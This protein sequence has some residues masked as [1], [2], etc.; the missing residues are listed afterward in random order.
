MDAFS[1]HLE[2]NC[3]RVFS[4][5]TDQNFLSICIDKANEGEVSHDR[6]GILRIK[7][8]LNSRRPGLSMVIT[9]KV[10]LYSILCGICRHSVF[11]KIQQRSLAEED[12]TSVSIETETLKWLSMLAR[13]TTPD[14]Q[15]SYFL[16]RL[17]E[18]SNDSFL[19]CNVS[20]STFN[21]WKTIAGKQCPLTPAAMRNN[22]TFQRIDTKKALERLE[23]GQ[24]LLFFYGPPSKHDIDCNVPGTM[25]A[26]NVFAGVTLSAIQDNN[27]SRRQFDLTVLP[28]SS[29][30][31]VFPLV[32]AFEDHWY[33]IYLHQEVDMEMARFMKSILVGTGHSFSSDSISPH[34]TGLK[35]QFVQTIKDEEEEEEEEGKERN[36]NKKRKPNELA[37]SSS[38]ES[39]LLPHRVAIIIAKAYLLHYTPQ[40]LS[41]SLCGKVNRLNLSLQSES[42]D[43]DAQSIARNI[44]V[45]R[46]ADYIYTED[47]H[48][49]SV[50]PILRALPTEHRSLLSECGVFMLPEFRQD[51]LFSV[52]KMPRMRCVRAIPL[53]S[54]PFCPMTTRQDVLI[55]TL[56]AILIDKKMRA[57]DTQTAIID[58][59]AQQ[60]AETAREEGILHIRHDQVTVPA[61]LM[62]LEKKD[63]SVIN[64][65]KL[66]TIAMLKIAHR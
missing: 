52:M 56:L 6:N 26:E 57:H 19:L 59:I 24:L 49:C 34:E 61:Y 66:M 2:N 11:N 62:A 63:G 41:E 21:I 5:Q 8:I 33:R 25:G 9:S 42:H 31:D 45:P 53:V 14:D 48:V 50:T 51:V 18:C 36:P 55:N 54:T 30:K 65:D 13:Q 12:Q 47:N 37:V 43:D 46:M 28:F 16:K 3:L 15:P 38:D 10:A 27:D 4:G 60:V 17:E 1:C 39:A 35:R 64:I 7:T 23:A 22:S 29:Q 58:T 40:I 32:S 44:L 20:C